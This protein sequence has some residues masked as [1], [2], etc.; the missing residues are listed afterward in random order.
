[1]DIAE[2]SESPTQRLRALLADKVKRI[3]ERLFAG[4]VCS[5]ALA[6]YHAIRKLH[7][8]L[9]GDDLYEAVI[10]RR[11]NLD[12]AGARAIVWRTHASLEDWNSDRGPTFRDVVKYMIV[13]EYLGQEAEERGMNLDLGPFLAKRVDVHF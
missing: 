4:R 1:V 9:Q 7:P 8:E 6:A 5:E 11:L 2:R 12:A 10:A 3:E 13:S